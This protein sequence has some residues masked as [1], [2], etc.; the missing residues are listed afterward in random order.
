MRKF[1][2]LFLLLGLWTCR[3]Q[4][5]APSLFAYDSFRLITDRN[6]LIRDALRDTYRPSARG[7]RAVR[8]DSFALVGT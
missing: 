6:I 5:N 1:F 7:T 3:A 4:T 2:S 8:A